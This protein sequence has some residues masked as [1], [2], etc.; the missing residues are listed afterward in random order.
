VKAG[1]LEDRAHRAVQRC[2]AAV[3]PHEPE[4]H[5]Q[6]RRL[7]GAVGA[8]ERGDATG[9]DLEGEAVDGGR[10][11]VVLAELLDSDHA[12]SIGASGAAHIG[13]EY[14]LRAPSSG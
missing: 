13:R 6:R 3:G 2:R 12:N 7:A 8:E 1:V 4:D 14:E 11:A 10:R 9:P 5:P